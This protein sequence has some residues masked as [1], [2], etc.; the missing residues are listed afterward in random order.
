MNSMD[1]FAG[2]CGLWLSLYQ[3]SQLEFICRQKNG[4]V[5]LSDDSLTI[6]DEGSKKKTKVVSDKDFKHKL[7][8]H[9]GILRSQPKFKIPVDCL[10]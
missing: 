7:M 6:T 5:S 1:S 2:F 10:V 9:F 8:D 3:L 4:R